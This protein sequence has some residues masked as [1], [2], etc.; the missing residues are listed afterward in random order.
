MVPL[1]KIRR[2]IDTLRQ[3][4]LSVPELL[5][6]RSRQRLVDRALL[7]QPM[8]DGA[9]PPK[10]KIAIFLI[11]QP[12]GVV[13]STIDTCR[14]LSSKGYAVLAV[15]N[16]GLSTRDTELLHPFVWRFVQRRNFGYDFGGY[17]DGIRLLW[18]WSVV[19]EC[20]I[21]LNDSIWFPVS[22][23]ESMIDKMEISSAGFVGATRHVDEGDTGGEHA[24]IFLSYFLLIKK[25]VFLSAAFVEFWKNYVSTSNKY[26]TVRRGE[27]HFSRVLFLA[28]A[29]SEGIYSRNRL[30]NCVESQPVPVLE[31]MLQYAAYTD[32][33]FEEERNA[34]LK[35][36]DRDVGWRQSVL[37]HVSAVSAKKNF[38]SSFCYASI[39]LL[40]VPFLKKN[41]G[42][43]QVRMRRQYV[44][45]VLAGDLP[46]PDEHVFKE[47]ESSVRSN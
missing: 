12:D 32:D 24:G 13:A 35:Q 17:R 26:L 34:L 47:I 27:R 11:F 5:I 37:S 31:L 3:Q 28:G 4:L 33:R 36:R 30:L 18:S 42:E 45:A 29:P 41:S 10:E 20:L 21:I 15:F 46:M 25:S 2:E 40:G 23:G 39:G 16:S 19:P 14:Y 7:R 43:L 22:A 44:N 1:W 9:Q 38:H 6:G 8:V